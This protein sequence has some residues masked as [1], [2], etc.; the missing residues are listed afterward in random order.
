[1]PQAGKRHIASAADD[2]SPARKHERHDDGAPRRERSA[3]ERP[4]ARVAARPRG[5]GPRPASLRRA[6]RGARPGARAPR[7]QAGQPVPHA[8]ANGAPLVKVLDFGISKRIKADAT[9]LTNT[10][11]L[12]GS[13]FYMAPEQMRRAMQ[14]AHAPSRRARRTAGTRSSSCATPRRRPWARGGTPEPDGGQAWRGSAGAPRQPRR[15]PDRVDRRPARRA[16]SRAA[17]RRVAL[18]ATNPPSP[19]PR[20]LSAATRARGPARARPRLLRSPDLSELGRRGWPPPRARRD[21]G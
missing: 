13:P 11:V 12:L 4:R 9:D 6:G 19:G 3:A 16:R 21:R 5:G 17:H 14:F 8:P 7:P 15:T 1:M 2:R 18:H 20:L 10:L